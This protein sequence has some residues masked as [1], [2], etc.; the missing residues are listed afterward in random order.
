MS[1]FSNKCDLWDWFSMVREANETPFQCYLRLG[2]KLYQDSAKYPL[3]ESARIKIEKPSDLVM[4]YP[5]YDS[6][7]VYERGGKDI[8]VLCKP[9]Y[10]EYTGRFFHDAL[11][12]EYR[13]VSIEEDP[14]YVQVF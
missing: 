3:D 8:H 10:G 13:R 1:R 4:Y 6:V 7:H 9:K 11:M 12:Q 5:Y 2:T 14:D